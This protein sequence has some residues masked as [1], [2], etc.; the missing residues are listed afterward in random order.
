MSRPLK[1]GAAAGVVGA[2]ILFS[3]LLG[4]GRESIL[5]TLIGIDEEG[6]LYRQAFLIPDLLNYLL[7]G[8]Y[9]TITLIPI[10]SRHLARD[11]QEAA[12][13]A[14]TSVF[15]FV[16]VAI[17]GLTALMWLAADPLV[18]LI[19]PEVP[20]PDRL[21]SL[22]RLV[23]PAQVFLVMGALLMAVQYTHRRFL[24]PALAPIVYN[25]GIIVGGLIGAVAGEAGPEGF[26]WGAVIGSALGNF[27]LQWVGARS[28][29]TWLTVVPR[30]ESSV[31]EYLTLALPL[32]LGQSVAVLDEQFVRW[33]GQVEE[34]ATAALSFARQLGMVPIGVIAQAAGV[35]AFPFLARL[36]AGDDE[37]GL[38]RA[39]GRAARNTVFVAAAATAALVVL[40]RPMVR[41]L[42]QHGEFTRDDSMIVSGLLV[43]YAFSIP[44]WG[45]HQILSRHFYAKRLMWRVVLIGTAGT[46]VAIPVWFGLYQVMG[47]EG[48]ALA[49]TLVMTAYALALLVAWGM[50]AGWA[51]VRALVPSLL[52]GLVAAGVAALVSYPLVSV[53]F[54]Q[55]EMSVLEGL[56]AASLGGLT[57]VAA[58]LGVAYLLRAPEL[59][60]LLRRG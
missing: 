23:L 17:V 29:G 54:D 12:S 25:L 13:R 48:F 42:Y 2:S 22:T 32:M 55:D 31:R 18:S 36:A 11:D 60:D 24:L 30:D 57:T 53:L 34:G 51:P 47:V 15:R 33:F 44:A 7:A 1:M 9:L 26:L 14:F 56:A 43:I 27:A 10:L 45:L 16:G 52:R 38:I 58:F 46:L 49:S 41:L 6:D 19:F 28:T 4:L 21:V 39:T 40:A 5:A 37:E 59:R 35:A 8:A 3:R 20:D 50:E